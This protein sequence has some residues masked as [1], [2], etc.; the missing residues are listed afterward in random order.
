M[1]TPPRRKE[2]YLRVTKEA[3]KRAKLEI[4]WD[5]QNGTLPALVQCF[6]DLHDFANAYGY[7]GADKTAFGKEVQEQLDAWIKTGVLG[8][9]V[10]EPSRA[11]RAQRALEY[12]KADLGEH[13]PIDADTVRDLM[14]DTL[15]WLTQ[16][17]PPNDYPDPAE[18]L[19]VAAHMAIVDFP[20]GREALAAIEATLSPKRKPKT[21]RT[22]Q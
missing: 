20:E 8:R 3:V 4:L 14:Q 5:V 2:A 21:K 22:P 6:S 7:G 10:S 9:S 16:Q 18:T 15:H 1:P 13:G 19:S 17:V 12:Y 11:I